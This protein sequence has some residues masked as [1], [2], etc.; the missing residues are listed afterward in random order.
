[1][2]VL[3]HEFQEQFKNKQ[4]INNSIPYMLKKSGIKGHNGFILLSKKNKKKA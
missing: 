3:S 1:M 2:N 4:F